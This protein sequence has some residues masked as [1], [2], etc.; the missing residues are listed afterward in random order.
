MAHEF[1][2]HI[3]LSD[4][5][6]EIIESEAKDLEMTLEELFANTVAVIVNDIV[7]TVKARN[8]QAEPEED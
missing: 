6:H 1:E 8:E 3:K 7:E 2:L 4:E 5:Q